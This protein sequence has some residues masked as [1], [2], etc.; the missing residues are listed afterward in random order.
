METT[1]RHRA[2]DA[3]LVAKAAATEP[4]PQTQQIDLLA[5]FGLPGEITVFVGRSVKGEQRISVRLRTGTESPRMVGETYFVDIGRDTLQELL[6]SNTDGKIDTEAQ[7][8]IMNAQQQLNK[9][10]D[11]KTRNSSS[12]SATGAGR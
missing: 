7:T 6:D 2:R 11:I 3:A 4:T 12:T 10:L 8:R 9:L 1:R 5:L